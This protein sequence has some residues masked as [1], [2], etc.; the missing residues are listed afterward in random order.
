VSP[1]DFEAVEFAT[2][3]WVWWFNHHRLLEPMG[4]LPPPEY[5]ENFH[6]ASATQ[7][8]HAGEAALT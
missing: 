5:E 3:E 2:L 7:P 4:Y 8:T 6:H 1:G